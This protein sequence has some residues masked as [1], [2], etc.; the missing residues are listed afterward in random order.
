MSIITNRI[1]TKGWTILDLFDIGIFFIEN[2]DFE[3]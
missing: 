3:K 1:S 2:S